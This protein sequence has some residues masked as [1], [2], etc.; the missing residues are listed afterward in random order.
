MYISSQKQIRL[1]IFHNHRIGCIVCQFIPYDRRNV[2]SFTKDT[3]QK[4][5]SDQEDTEGVFA[6]PLYAE[7]D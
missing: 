5:Q 1:I 4:Q 6:G 7:Q 3:W 2:H